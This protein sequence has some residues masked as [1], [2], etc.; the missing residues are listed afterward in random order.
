MF[1]DQD[2]ELFILAWQIIASCLSSCLTKLAIFVD[3]LLFLFLRIKSP[4]GQAFFSSFVDW[5]ERKC[6]YWSIS[7]G[8]NKIRNI[9]NSQ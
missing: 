1:F 7:D 2:I 8:R 5:L 4:T 9:L 3:P 6:D